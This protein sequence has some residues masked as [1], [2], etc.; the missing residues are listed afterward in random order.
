MSEVG[1]F[2][3]GWRVGKGLMGGSFDRGCLEGFAGF[4]ELDLI[5]SFYQRQSPPSRSGRRRQL[6]YWRVL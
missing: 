2:D 1:G 6:G 3:G 4:P 5:A